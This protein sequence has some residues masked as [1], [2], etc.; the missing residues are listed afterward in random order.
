M[1]IESTENRIKA[2]KKE[3]EL[4]MIELEQLKKDGDDPRWKPKF[5]DECHYVKGSGV[6]VPHRWLD[7]NADGKLLA[8]GNIFKSYKQAEKHAL[9]L[10]VFNNLWVLADVMGGGNDEIVV[11]PEGV[12]SEGSGIAVYCSPKFTPR[13]AKKAIKL[14]GESTIKEAWS[15]E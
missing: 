11:R 13:N 1:S 8:N 6:V 14:I 10:N 7:T 3:L 12:L 5:E 2:A 15:N 4:A 9:R